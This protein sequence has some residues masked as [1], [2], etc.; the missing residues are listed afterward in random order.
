VRLH[1]GS[2]KA[3]NSADGGL[4]VELKFPLTANETPAAKEAIPVSSSV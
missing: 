1:G 4:V 3:E 2:V